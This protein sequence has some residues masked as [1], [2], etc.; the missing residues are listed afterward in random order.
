[1]RWWGDWFL[2]GRLIPEELRRCT[3]GGGNLDEVELVFCPF[4]DGV[5]V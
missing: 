2:F 1:M 3:E 5:D 4:V